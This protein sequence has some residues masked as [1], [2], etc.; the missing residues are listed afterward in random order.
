MKILTV[1]DSAVA[2]R[3]IRHDLEPAGYEVI[4]AGTGEDALDA[5]VAHQPDLVT[6]DVHMPGIDGY[7]TCRRIRALELMAD[8]N[9]AHGVPIVFVTADDTQA[10]RMEGFQAGAADFIVKPFLA[11]RVLRAV[12]SLLKPAPIRYG[13]RALVADDS[14]LV[15]RIVCDALAQ[16]GL[17]QVQV[18]TGREA[19]ERLRSDP[20]A[21]DLVVTDGFMPEMNGDALCHAIRAD[22]ALRHLP[23]LVLSGVEHPEDLRAIFRAGA[24]DFL[25]KPF[26]KEV[27]LSRVVALLHGHEAERALRR[28]L[29]AVYGEEPYR[30]A[31]QRFSQAAPLAGREVRPSTP[32]RPACNALGA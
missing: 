29:V 32:H 2:R 6:L 17:E 4:E 7:E 8:S 31:L 14:P 1:D 25:A 10:G 13:L 12:D 19:L 28:R 3:L 22:E 9:A 18:G 27:F 20:A 23:V 21:V 24:S 26:V 30:E 11:G 15:R 5:L 16:L